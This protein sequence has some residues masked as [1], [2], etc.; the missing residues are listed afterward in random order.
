M[1][2]QAEDGWDTGEKRLKIPT[3][4]T[5]AFY[6]T[7][8]THRHTHSVVLCLSFVSLYEQ[9]CTFIFLSL[10]ILLLTPSCFYSFLAFVCLG[11]PSV[12]CHPPPSL[13]LCLFCSLSV[14]QG[15]WNPL[16]YKEPLRILTTFQKNGAK[17]ICPP[18]FNS[19]VVAFTCVE[20]FNFTT[21]LQYLSHTNSLCLC[22]SVLLSLT[23][24]KEDLPL[25]TLGK[26]SNPC[27][28]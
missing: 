11:V 22:C 20:V 10:L 2:N 25:A 18:S 15:H 24:W 26:R 16:E 17:T 14:Q 6:Q 3:Y 13:S 7:T 19:L 5:N 21:R 9:T 28:G 12:S 27:L 1:R 8:H 4:T 23:R